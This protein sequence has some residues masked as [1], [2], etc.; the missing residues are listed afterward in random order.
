MCVNIKRCLCYCTIPIVVEGVCV[1][2]SGVCLLIIIIVCVCVCL[3]LSFSLS[4][5]VFLSLHSL[6]L[7]SF[8]CLLL[9][10]SGHSKYFELVIVGITLHAYVSVC[11]D[12]SYG[13]Y[14]TSTQCVCVTLYTPS[15]TE[16]S[17]GTFLIPPSQC[18]HI[19]IPSGTI[20]CN[21]LQPQYMYMYRCTCILLL[22]LEYMYKCVEA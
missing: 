18:A 13:R 19:S 21:S 1:G 11:F 3:S 6:T 15:V 17:L 8:L 4:L 10:L 14:C 2:Y 12:S 7:S 9:Y 16:G 22:Q 20:T 5:S